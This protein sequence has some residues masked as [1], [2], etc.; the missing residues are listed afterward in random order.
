MDPGAAT[1]HQGGPAAAVLSAPPIISTW[2]LDH[3]GRW[4]RPRLPA[5]H[6]LGVGAR[7]TGQGRGWLGAAR[8][9][10]CAKSPAKI[11]WGQLVDLRADGGMEGGARGL[12]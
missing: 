9:R 7:T 11:K 2:L 12:G 5:Y 1:H 6:V 10:R 3:R 4:P 8:A